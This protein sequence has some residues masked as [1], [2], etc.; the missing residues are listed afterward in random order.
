MSWEIQPEEDET[1]RQLK[2]NVRRAAN[3]LNLNVRYGDT[4]D[5][6]L[7]VWQEAPAERRGTR[8]RPRKNADAS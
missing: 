4:A 6:T 3:E 7:L 5:N 8:R 2:L 1:L